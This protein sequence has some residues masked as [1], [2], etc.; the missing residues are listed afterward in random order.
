LDLEELI[1]ADGEGLEAL[2]GLRRG[3]AELV[4][5]SPYIAMLLAEAPRDDRR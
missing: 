5:V 2:R 4:G 1:S 3:G